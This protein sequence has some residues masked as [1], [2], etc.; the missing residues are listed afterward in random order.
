M[1]YRLFATSKYSS[2]ASGQRFRAKRRGSGPRSVP[3]RVNGLPSLGHTN[4]W[5]VYNGLDWIPLSEHRLLSTRSHV[6]E[7][8]SRDNGRQETEVSGSAYR[9]DL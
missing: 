8:S 9:E 7:R 2:I 5:I 3:F 6:A 1:G 4:D